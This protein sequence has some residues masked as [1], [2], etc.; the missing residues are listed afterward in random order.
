MVE[1]LAVLEAHLLGQRVAQAHGDAAFHLLA[2]AVRVD[3]DAL[4]LR[5][6]PRARPAR[7]RCSCRPP[8]PPWSPRRCPSRCRRR[9]RR[10]ARWAPGPA[11][12]RTASR[13]P[14]ARAACAGRSGGCRRNSTGSTPA[15]LARMSMCDSRAKVL[16][17]DRRRAP[18]PD[19]ERVHARRI[20][21]L[22]AARRDRALVRNVVELLCAAV[23]GAVDLVVPE[24]R[25]CPPPVRPER[26]L[27]HRRRPEGVVEELLG[28]VPH[29]LHGL[30]G[31]SSPAAPLR[32]PGPGVR[33]LPPKP[34]PT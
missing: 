12:S 26:I 2:R 22:P 32:R 14:P 5:A 17:V 23:A 33:L 6:R 27:T 25:S 30:A 8:P 16:R 13:R 18:R 28:A 24:R 15:L 29:H 10:R 20:S 7:A 31:E 11:S 3:G 9:R 21:A 1:H 4:V 19:A 34:P